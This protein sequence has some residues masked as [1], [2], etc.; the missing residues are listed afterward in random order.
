MLAKDNNNNKASF[1]PLE[2]NS[3]SKIEV[4][5]EQTNPYKDPSIEYIIN[6]WSYQINV[7]KALPPIFQ[8]S[9]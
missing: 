6:V 1:S 2:R 9:L 3:R 8:L 7:Q 4:K 5:P